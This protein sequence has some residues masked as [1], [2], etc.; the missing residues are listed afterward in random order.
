M[1]RRTSERTIRIPIKV[2][3][4]QITYLYGGQLPDL[5][6]CHFGELV[7]PESAVKDAATRGRLNGERLVSFLPE[8]TELR[9]RVSKR[10]APEMLEPKV[11]NTVVYG[12]GTVRTVPF[13]LKTE[14]ALRWRGAKFPTLEPATYLIPCLPGI[15]PES[16]N[17]ACRLISEAFE[18]HRRSH[19]ANVFSEVFV[20]D[21][22]RWV[23]LDELRAR[24]GQ[25]LERSLLAGSGND[26][27]VDNNG[28]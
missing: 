27:G 5:L 12:L 25:L 26:Q 9:L 20:Q 8:T 1:G 22:A 2:S 18:P 28:P 14:L 19:A 4:G 17:H 24:I 13:R 3:Q 11:V 23:E 15:E 10:P 21:R 16:V 7:L 6:D